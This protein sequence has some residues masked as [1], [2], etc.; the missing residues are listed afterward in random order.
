MTMSFNIKG[1]EI[2]FHDARLYAGSGSLSKFAKTFGAQGSKSLFCYEFFKSIPE[3]IERK[4]EID[5][6]PPM[7]I[8]RVNQSYHESREI[9]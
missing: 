3:A 7:G 4:R 2:A 1:Q 5:Q 8:S 9:I 6:S